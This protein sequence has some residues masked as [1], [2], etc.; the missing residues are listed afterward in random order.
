M[1]RRRYRLPPDMVPGM[2]EPLTA[3]LFKLSAADRSEALANWARIGEGDRATYRGY[4]DA[5]RTDRERASRCR[6]LMAQLK[7]PTA[8]DGAEPDAGQ[9]T[10][11]QPAGL[12]KGALGYAP[13]RRPD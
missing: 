12:N 7:K 8:S 3:R 11:G 10:N 13:R 4:L 1:P 2:P 9:P 6:L 5:A